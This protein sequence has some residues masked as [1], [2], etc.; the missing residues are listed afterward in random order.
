M[1]RV[2]EIKVIVNDCY[3][4]LC[5]VSAWPDDSVDGCGDNDDSEI[6][7]SD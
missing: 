4:V 7:D 1:V 2:S 3:L 6:K 5:M